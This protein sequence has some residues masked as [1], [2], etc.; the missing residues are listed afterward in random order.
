VGK[1][2]VL[3]G[4]VGLGTGAPSSGVN[5]TSPGCIAG[6]RP[7]GRE[8]SQ[9]KKASAFCKGREKAQL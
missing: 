6:A 5:E 8:K 9:S 4:K 3:V 2:N 1:E 7:G